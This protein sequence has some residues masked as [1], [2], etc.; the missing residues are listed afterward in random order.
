MDKVDDDSD[1]GATGITPSRDAVP[2][3]PG[4]SEE[5]EDFDESKLGFSELLQLTV[6]TALLIAI[7]RL[8]NHVADMFV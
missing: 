1:T 6:S 3:L 5:V 4:V 8:L 2:Y 7:V